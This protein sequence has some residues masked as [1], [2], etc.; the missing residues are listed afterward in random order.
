MKHY[1]FLNLAEQ[2]TQS[3]M[4]KIYPE[5]FKAFIHAGIENDIINPELAKMDL[6]KLAKQ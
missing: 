4:T 2:A 3:E 5:A 1:P 6:D